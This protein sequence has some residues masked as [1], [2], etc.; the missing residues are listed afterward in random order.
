[1]FIFVSLL[2]LWL[3]SAQVQCLSFPCVSALMEYIVSAGCC[4]EHAQCSVLQ[5]DKMH[6]TYWGVETHAT[7]KLGFVL[8]SGFYVQLEAA[9]RHEAAGMFVTPDNLVQ[10][11]R[12]CRA[13]H[14]SLN[15]FRFLWST[16]WCTVVPV[17]TFCVDC[18][19][20]VASLDS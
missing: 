16:S 20:G 12:S 1:M 13:E 3:E 9:R 4:S 8:G 17:M 18:F 14:L 10:Q 19:G 5:L 7:E 2:K 6:W 15:I 11:G